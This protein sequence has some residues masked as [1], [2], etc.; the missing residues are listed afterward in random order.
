MTT[1]PI[2]FLLGEC[3]AEEPGELQ[4]MGSQKSQDLQTKQQTI[5]TK[6]EGGTPQG[7]YVT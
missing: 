3:W 4:F 7:W 1:H 6:K 2:V 5:A